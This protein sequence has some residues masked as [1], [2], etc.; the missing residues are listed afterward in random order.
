ME[1]ERNITIINNLM[2][3]ITIDH[4]LLLF[5]LNQEVLQLKL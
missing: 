2:I 4:Y 5:S 1:S 3:I